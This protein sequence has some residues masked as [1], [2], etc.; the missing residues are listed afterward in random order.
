[1]IAE[2]L[3]G[4]TQ[5][6][7]HNAITEQMEKPPH[8]EMKISTNDVTIFN[9]FTDSLAE[10]TETRDFANDVTSFALHHL[11]KECRTEEIYNC[12]ISLSS[13]N[14]NALIKQANTLD[15]DGMAALHYTVIRPSTLA[16]RILLDNKIELDVQSKFGETP[17]H[18]AIR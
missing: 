17:F 18:L 16:A 5:R 3:A 12:F 8:I 4:I 7:L 9:N 15:F 6:V 11:V 10:T 2:V 14:K 1:M 13:E